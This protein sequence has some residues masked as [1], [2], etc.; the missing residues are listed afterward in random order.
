MKS[1]GGVDVQI[2]IFLTSA[3]VRGECSASRSGRF[4]PRER[5]PGTHWI[6]GWVVPRVGLDDAKRKLLTVPGLRPLGYLVS[7]Y[8]DYAIAAPILNIA[9]PGIYTVCYSCDAGSL[10]RFKSSVSHIFYW[11]WKCASAKY[12][13]A[14]ERRQVAPPSTFRR[15]CSN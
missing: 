14:P 8:T 4:I 3:L 10:N 15:T 9:D 13:W 2:H 11:N 7:R 12:L 6:G 1:Y 5:A